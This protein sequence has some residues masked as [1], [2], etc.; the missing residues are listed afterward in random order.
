[1]LL[2]HWPAPRLAPYIEKLW[3]CEAY[4]AAHRYE[5]V[6]PNGTFQL[7]IDLAHALPPLVVGMRSRYAILDT[8]AL[9]SII[10]VLF[11]PGG[12][13]AF[14][15]APADAFYN[16]E[17]P[18]DLVWGSAAMGLRVRLQ[19]ASTPAAKFRALEAAVERRVKTRL[20]LHAAVRYGLAEFRR[21]PHARS[22]LSV[23]RE[24]GLS[25]RRFSQLFREQVGLTPKLYCR[26]YRFQQVVRQIAAGGP[27]DWADVALAGGYCDQAHL[28]HEFRDF[29]GISPGAYLASDPPFPNH[30]PMD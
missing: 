2:E 8:A 16:R 6:L 18:L 19:E 3:Y 10:G 25:R 11:R 5:R 20:E 27:V 4:G 13:R 7:V 22:V 28:A 14:F 23:T 26:L 24:A 15:D 12:A 29:S 1:M 17:I 30:V 21:V 9:R